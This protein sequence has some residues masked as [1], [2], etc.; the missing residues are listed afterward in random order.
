MYKM[1][2]SE[3]QDWKVKLT[4]A[5]LVS[6]DRIGGC[7]YHCGV[8]DGWEVPVNQ[9]KLVFLQQDRPDGLDLGVGKRFTG[10]TVTPCER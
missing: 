3:S 5:S 1:Q 4:I 7:V 10:T 6:D 8:I 2:S 9:A